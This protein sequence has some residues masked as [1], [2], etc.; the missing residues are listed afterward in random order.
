MVS[1]LGN[2][3][4]A[5]F[6]TGDNMT[7]RERKEA[8]IERLR[9]WAE[10]RRTVA[11]AALNSH[12][13]IRHDWAFIT[14]P[15]HSSVRERMNRS[16]DRAIQSLD[17]ANAMQTRAAGIA[18]QL[19]TSIYADDTDAVEALRARI[20]ERETERERMKTVNK[21]YKKGDV[22]GLAALGL[23][24][25]AIT[26]KLTAA[27]PYWGKAPYMPYELTN[28]SAKIRTDQKRI[29]E[30]KQRHERTTKAHAAGGV[31]IEGVDYIRA[32]FADK[33]EH[34]LIERLKSA[35]FVWSGGSWCGYRSRFPQ[36]ILTAV[37][38]DDVTP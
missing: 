5:R 22:V 33:P 17:K 2:V 13:E 15:G 30:L 1:D 26:A 35:G 7:T 25:D 20:A 21:L 19:D 10:K 28:L 11:T 24:L 18:A 12:P 23:N 4:G 8:K 32:T 16:D 29:E 36:E 34:P 37:A 31:V 9:V 3:G 38:A 6:E 27:G 14:Q